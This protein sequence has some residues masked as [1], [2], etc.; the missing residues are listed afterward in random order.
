[1]VG[2]LLTM[3]RLDLSHPPRLPMVLPSILSADFARLGEECRLVLGLGADGLHVDVMDG[4][5]VPNLTMG[6]AIV[7]SLRAA[8]PDAWLDVHLMVTDPGQMLVPFAKAG[9]DH[10]TFHAE[11]VPAADRAAMAGRIRDLGCTAGLAL[12]PDRPI[13]T[14]ADSFGLFDMVLVMSVFPGFSGQSFIED[15]IERCREVRQLVG[16]SVRVEM[17][18]G[19]APDTAKR[20]RE[21]GCDMLVAASAIFGVQDDAKQEVIENLR[22]T[23]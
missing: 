17:D 21:A 7:K 4:H 3:A 8:L 6:P 5:F 10:L 23:E 13:E 15:S 20:V 12:N 14:D 1:V 2:S 11:V 19:I 22:G 18:G 9:A 16:N